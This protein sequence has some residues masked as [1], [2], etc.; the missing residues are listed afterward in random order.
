MPSLEQIESQALV[1]RDCELCESVRNKVFGEGAPDASAM[2]VG[3][4]PGREE[5]A[6]G[7]P[8]VGP[9][10]QV[11]DKALTKL[12]VERDRVYIAN[13]LKCRPPRN[14]LPN[15]PEMTA[16][17]RWLDMQICAVEPK[18]I[19][20]L[21]KTAMQQLL[22]LHISIGKAR[23]SVFAGP[24]GTKVVPTWH[25]SY[26]LRQSGAERKKVAK[27]FLGDMIDA[28]ALAGMDFSE[29]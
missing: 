16:C 27:E 26:L 11:L 21:G 22:E 24:H 18:V 2:L 28:F 3:E 5:D 15:K 7:R 17:L 29:G 12:G 23:G 19:L 14:R 8:F 13:I 25:P 9:A 4:A 20:A 10:G 1:C 6:I